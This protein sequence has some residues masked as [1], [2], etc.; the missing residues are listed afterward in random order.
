MTY[1][2]YKNKTTGEGIKKC[3]CW[4]CLIPQ[5]DLVK[6][7]EEFWNTRIEGDRQV[8]HTIKAAIDEPNLQQAE[9]YIKAAGLKLASGNLL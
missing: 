6:K 4:E 7:R 1:L 8:W 2:E 3:P 5:E 9:T